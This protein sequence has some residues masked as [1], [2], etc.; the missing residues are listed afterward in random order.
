MDFILMTFIGNARPVA[1]IAIL[2]V[3]KVNVISV[4]SIHL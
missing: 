4:T 2:V 3:L 1:V